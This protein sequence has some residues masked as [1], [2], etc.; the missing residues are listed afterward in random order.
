MQTNISL[1]LT[2]LGNEEEIFVDVDYDKLSNGKIQ[3]NYI[4]YGE[5]DIGKLLNPGQVEPIKAFLSL[6]EEGYDV[7]GWK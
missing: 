5:T 6:K 3:I 7:E 2:I 4:S 1:L